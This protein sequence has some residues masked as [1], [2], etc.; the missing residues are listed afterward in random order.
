[1]KKVFIDC[2][3]NVGEVLS[4]FMKD[5]PDHQFHAFEANIDLIST[6]E[7]NIKQKQNFLKVHIH[8]K[9]VWVKDGTINLY[10]GHHES[11]TVLLGKKVPSCYN[12]Q[13]DYTAPRIVECIDFSHWLVQNFDL[14]DKITVKMDIEGAEYDV[15]EH[16][17]KQGTINYISQLFVEWHY[18]RYEY[19]SF[20]RHSSLFSELNKYIK[21][22]P[23][24]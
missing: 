14:K 23:W 15:L 4:N 24:H 11:S 9:A 19:I 10:L 5:L 2:G 21:V 13:I 7:E 17:L 6:I 16:L 12:Q 18:D 8:N 20:E 22:L 3:A 1:M